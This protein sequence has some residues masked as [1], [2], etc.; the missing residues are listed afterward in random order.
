MVGEH[1]SK[2]KD[3]KKLYAISA[4]VVILLLTGILLLIKIL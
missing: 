3:G 4:I 1:L 2:T